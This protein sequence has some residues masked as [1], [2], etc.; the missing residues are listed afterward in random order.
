MKNLLALSILAL[1]A[2]SFS[3]VAFA[4]GQSVYKWTD[5]LGVV[6]YSDKPPTE[7]APDLQSMDLPAFPPQDPAK[8]A[9]EQA[10]LTASTAAL[11]Q[12]QQAE[13]AL[14]QRAEELALERAQL[15]ATQEAL[16]LDAE[17]AAQPAPV[18]AIYADSPFIPRSFH[19][20]MF[21]HH[22]FDDRKPMFTDHPMVQRPPLPV[23]H[24]P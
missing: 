9:A 7:A 17:A 2:A 23:T 14:Q 10:A 12:Q 13:E 15:Q 5:A 24:R 22:H 4:D 16:R 11:V 21:E 1:L 20:N 8:I 6:H 3:A 18:Y 19:R